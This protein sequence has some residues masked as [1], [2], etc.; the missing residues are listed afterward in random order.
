M[1]FIWS[2]NDGPHCHTTSILSQL[3]PPIA[4]ETVLALVGRRLSQKLESCG[5]PNIFSQ[6]SCSI[7]SNGMNHIF[8]KFRYLDC[9]AT[10]RNSLA[11]SSD[12]TF[13]I[14]VIPCIIPSDCWKIATGFFRLPTFLWLQQKKLV[15]TCFS[16]CNTIFRIIYIYIYICIYIYM[17]IYIHIY[18]Y[19]VFFYFLYHVYIAPSVKTHK[20]WLYGYILITQ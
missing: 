11:M 1:E 6:S 9:Y 7:L 10:G 13:P 18:I 20:Q 16:I 15:I 12:H 17:H 14:G 3:E 4:W 2:P 5:T 19:Q 8:R